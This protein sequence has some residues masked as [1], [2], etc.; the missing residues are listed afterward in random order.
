M[1]K[2]YGPRIDSC[3]HDRLDVCRSEINIITD[4]N[5][6]IRGIT[7]SFV[8]DH[9]TKPG[10]KLEYGSL[11]SPYHGVRLTGED[12]IKG[13]KCIVNLP[14]YMNKLVHREGV[15]IQITN[16]NHDKVIFID[17]IDILNN[18]FTV[19]VNRMFTNKD[20]KFHWTFTAERK[21]VDRIKNE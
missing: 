11:E 14:D 16:V 9:P 13:R 18:K 12:I 15:N 20:L 2:K 5:G 7:K 8:I 1:N 17:E 10:K 3:Y 6:S 21:D 19:K 4:V